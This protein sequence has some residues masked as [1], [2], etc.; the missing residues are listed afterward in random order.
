MT[1]R[2]AANRV[3]A[4]LEAAAPLWYGPR[5]EVV[6]LSGLE[7]HPWSFQFDLVVAAPAGRHR[8]V[9][10]IPRWDEAPTLA[11]ALAAGPQEGTGRE[12][13]ALE[14]LAAAVGGSGDPG[15]VAVAPVAYLRE[16]NAVVTERLEAV[17]LR[18]RLGRWPGS[19]GRQAETLRR[20]GRALRLYHDSVAGAVEAAFDGEGLGA[21]LEGEAARLGAGG[22]PWRAV[23]ASLALQARGH[24]GGPAVVGAA[25]GDFNL[26][27]VLVTGDGRVAILDP[28]LVSG[29]LLA[30]AAKLLTDLRMVRWR[31]LSLGLLGRRG[32]TAAERAFLEGYGQADASLLGFLR[33]VAT[34][35]RGLE[36]EQRL[37]AWPALL[38]RPAAR[39]LR[40]YPLAELLRLG[41]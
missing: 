14:A 9:V 1:G 5:A 31:V 37:A 16:I 38:R 22:S 35:R 19:E 20:A 33:A 39:L 30:D 24:H 6:R 3:R 7:A 26:A 17:P 29:P 23:L 15:L 18:S 10:K 32:S 28:N 11:S 2:E 27:N 25:H 41:A 8:L 13:A 36:M 12:H 21:D 4:A 40:R 34:V